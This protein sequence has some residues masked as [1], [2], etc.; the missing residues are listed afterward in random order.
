MEERVIDVMSITPVGCKL[1]VRKCINKDPEYIILP[2]QAREQTNYVEILK[3]GSR[4]KVFS[5][6]DVGKKVQ[7]PDYADGLHF[8]S[9]G[10]SEFAIVN[11]ELIEPV[12]YE[13]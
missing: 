12:T 8:I 2:D 1:L 5:D 10:S 11:E 9:E 3:V 4:C 13:E 6:N 7:C